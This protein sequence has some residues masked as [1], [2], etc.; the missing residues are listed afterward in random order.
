MPVLSPADARRGPTFE[1]CRDLVPHLSE[2]QLGTGFCDLE[3]MNCCNS[4]QIAAFRDLADYSATLQA[5]NDGLLRGISHA[6]LYDIRNEITF[7]IFDLPYVWEIL[8]QD[9]TER[10]SR[11]LQGEKDD[12]R[13]DLSKESIPRQHMSLYEAVRLTSMLYSIMITFPIPRS[14]SLRELLVR[15]IMD[16]LLVGSFLDEPGSPCLRVALWCITIAGIS[17][18]ETSYEI[19]YLEA[20]PKLASCLEIWTWTQAEESLQQFVWLKCSCS[21]AGEEF[22]HRSWV[23]RLQSQEKKGCNG[24]DW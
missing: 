6:R 18:F 21:Q 10:L 2:A 16:A 7:R 23:H 5:Y 20:I 15:E 17:A 19:W 4:P 22:W 12:A 11:S 13:N 8:Q 14:R 3:E 9:D 24:E 1:H